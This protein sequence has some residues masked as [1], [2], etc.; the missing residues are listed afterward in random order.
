LFFDLIFAAV[1]S[2][3]STPLG[4]DYSVHGI[5]KYAFLLALVFLAWFGFTVFSTQFQLDDVLQRGLIIAQVFFVAVMAA[6]ATGPLSSRDSAGFAAA[7]GGV[8]V[9]LALQYVRVIGLPDTR[10][11]VTRRIV[12][13]I[14]AAVIWATSTVL[15]APAR[16]VA[17]AFALLIDIGNSWPTLPS[18]KM[19]PPGATHLPER[20][21]LL[22]IILLGEF[23]ASVMRGIESQMGWNLLPAAAAV[24]SLTLGFAI[25]S[26][27][28][29]GA[30]GWE[31]RHVRS[32]NDV[33]RLRI[34]IALHFLLF[35]GLGVLGIGARR[36]IA[37]PTGERF[38][39][40]EQWIIC[41]ATAGIMLIIMGIAATSEHHRGSCRPRIWITQGIIVAIVLA[42]A[43]LTSWILPTALLFVLF[44]CFL[45]QTALLLIN[46]HGHRTTGQTA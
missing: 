16:Y 43:S 18:T 27:Y 28:S 31:T 21:G 40:T 22:T 36:A 13:L 7:Y 37:L 19:L 35:V 10:P 17:W 3:L 15:P 12:L 33:R 46:Q 2:Q 4:T 23:V 32:A 14:G 39:L 42:F 29:E 34:W 38:N 5:V 30:N 9:I 41:S 20:F 25:W 44:L 1:I 45:A 11:S 6:N 26:C 24:L 8:R